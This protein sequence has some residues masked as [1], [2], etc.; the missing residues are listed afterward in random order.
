MRDCRHHSREYWTISKAIR[1]VTM[2]LAGAPTKISEHT[3]F[4]TRS[5]LDHHTRDITSFEHQ[6][7]YLV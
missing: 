2:L 6:A 4:K 7:Q 5:V 1:E 3:G